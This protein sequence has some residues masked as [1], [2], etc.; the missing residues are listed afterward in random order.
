MHIG[1]D[2]TKSSI[3]TID[4]IDHTHLSLPLALCRD[5]LV[6][7]LTHGL[8]DAVVYLFAFPWGIVLDWDNLTNAIREWSNGS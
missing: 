5:V 1:G 4:M 6:P 8:S 3:V 7:L 2:V